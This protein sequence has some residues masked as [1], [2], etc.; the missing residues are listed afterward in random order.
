MGFVRVIAYVSG[1]FEYATKP[2][3]G[4]NPGILVSVAL[5]IFIGLLLWTG[6]SFETVPA[7]KESIDVKLVPPPLPEAAAKPRPQPAPAPPPSGGSPAFGA[8]TAKTEQKVPE[9]EAPPVTTPE[10]AKAESSE[11]KSEPEKPAEAE[12]PKEPETPE[13]QSP[14]GMKPIPAQRPEPKKAEPTD[15]AAARARE[16]ARNLAPAKELFSEES[17]SSFRVRQSARKLSAR[18]RIMQLC[19][20][21][22]LEQVRRQRPGSFPDLLVPFGHSGGRISD[23]G[24]NASGGAFRSRG[25]WYNISFRCTVDNSRSRVVSFSFSVGDQVPRSDWNGRG[26]LID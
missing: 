23:Y 7:P 8:A 1:M 25:D 24:L 11:E 16:T 18:D 22:A 19:T 12:K 2:W 5:H 21:E 15:P 10:T 20:I 26:L 17:L 13:K 4:L 9:K 14:D 3:R 6:L